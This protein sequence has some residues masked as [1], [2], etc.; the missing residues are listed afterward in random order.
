[1]LY[2]QYIYFTKAKPSHKRQTNPLIREGFTQE[3][4]NARVQL[5]NISGPEP[6][7]IWGQDELI[8]A[9]LPVVK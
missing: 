9:K 8:Y 3:L 6:R 7:G 2:V 5:Q 1:M 4:M